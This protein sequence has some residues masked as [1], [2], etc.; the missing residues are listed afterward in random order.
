MFCF[1]SAKPLPAPETHITLPPTPQSRPK[2]ACFRSIP[3]NPPLGCQ[4]RT[5]QCVSFL[6]VPLATRPALKGIHITQL[7]KS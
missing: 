5:L 6:D 2:L 3:A 7:V 1:Q 4:N